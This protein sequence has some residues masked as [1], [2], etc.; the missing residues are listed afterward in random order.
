MTFTTKFKEE[1]SKIEDNNFEKRITL[2]SFLN[3]ASKID[4]KIVI[5]SETASVIRKVYQDIKSIYNIN[6]TITV[7]MQKR[8]KLK[9]IYILEINENIE[10]IKKSIYYDNILEFCSSYEEKI[11]FLKGAFLAG[12]SITDPKNS[13][14][15]LEF[16]TSKEKTAIDINTLLNSMNINS[17]TLKRSNKYIVYVKAAEEISDLLKMFKCI[18]SLFYYED[19]RIYR[20]HKN[21]VNRLT[22]CEIANQEK[23]FK[24]GLTQLE[25]IKFLKEKGL[26][27]LLDDKTKTVIEYREKY[28]E[29][30][31]LELS[32]LITEDTDY[33]IGKSGINHNFI[34]INEL[35]KKYKNGVTDEN[36]T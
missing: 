26:I 35:V 12:G 21:T 27:D 19:I 30:S 9:Q 6:P 23:T 29:A 8:F 14:Y 28:P 10:L 2:I 24:T 22:N 33:K 4:E 3:I 7:R 18:N 32:E 1:L 16:S 5:N 25:S 13:G 34:K 31:Y 11:S 17:K 36:I 15:H 20:D